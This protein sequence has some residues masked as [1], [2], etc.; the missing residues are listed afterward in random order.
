MTHYKE[1][2]YFPRFLLLVT[3]LQCLFPAGPWGRP[4][5][6]FN[7]RSR[8]SFFRHLTAMDAWT[9]IWLHGFWFWNF[10]PDAN[11][12]LQIAWTSTSIF[13]WMET[14]RMPNGKL[15]WILTSFFLKQVKSPAELS[16]AHDFS[17]YKSHSSECWHWTGEPR[18]SLQIKNCRLW[19]KHWN[20]GWGWPRTTWILNLD[21]QWQIQLLAD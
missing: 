3:W 4:W 11:F 7:D 12:S 21:L 18:L 17:G 1:M 19:C 14:P 15:R 10:K 6:H 8:T 2:L 13:F 20:L 16:E 5:P 9:S